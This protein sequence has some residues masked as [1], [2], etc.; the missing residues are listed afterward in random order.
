MIN[1]IS[2][3]VLGIKGPQAKG[4]SDS[5]SRVQETQEAKLERVG[6]PGSPVFNISSISGVE[7]VAETER[8][9][10]GV[11]DDLNQYAQAV[12]RQL[13][14]SVDDESGKTIVKVLDAETGDTIRE[15]PAEE[16]L[17]MQKRLQE[18]SDMLFSNEES[19]TSLLF[20]EKA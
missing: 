18:V 9:L 4:G 7:D 19:S 5:A 15:I 14:F 10:D 6:L 13:Q 16:V 12:K 3:S 2:H 1:D 11:V 17:N 8:N 20:S